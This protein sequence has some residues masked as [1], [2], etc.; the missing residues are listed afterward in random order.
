MLKPTDLGVTGHLTT[1]KQHREKLFQKLTKM[2]S[3]RTPN[4]KSAGTIGLKLLDA[5]SGTKIDITG[6]SS[7]VMNEVKNYFPEIAGPV[8]SLNLLPGLKPTD[9]TYFSN[10]SSEALYDFKVFRGEEEILVSNK[11]M[12]GGTNTLKPK[13]VVDMIR[14][15]SE[16]SR[17]WANKKQYKVF[18]ELNNKNVISGPISA[19]MKYYPKSFQ[20]NRSDYL[21]VINQ[22]NMNDVIIEQVPKSFMKIIEN[23]PNVVP[24]FQ[25]KGH[26]SGTMINFLFERELA[27]ISSED[28]QYNQLFLDAT[29]NN[30]LFFKFGIDSRGIIKYG[31]DD[32][33]TQKK[34]AVLRPKNGVD[35]R[36]KSSGRLKLDKLGFQP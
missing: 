31:Y 6:V 35:R 15:N 9:K 32:P 14:S 19:I 34:P 7:F 18:V 24:Y 11:Q 28:L 21:K 26:V 5:S 22:M 2:A 30:V 33:N 4:L 12:K 16:L 17:K 13:N 23:D 3:S 25:E 20:I 1:I 29:R 10:S 8:W 36:S 27:R